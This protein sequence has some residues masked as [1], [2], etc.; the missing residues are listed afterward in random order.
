M[1]LKL[2]LLLLIPLLS[3]TQI[4]I[5]NNQ[6]ICSGDSIQLTANVSGPASGCTGVSDSLVTQVAGG[7][8]SAGTTFNVI[9]T[10]GSPLD[11]TGI[12]QGGTYT[13]TNNP[14]E[15]WM[16]AGDVYANPLPI[17][18]PPYP[19]WVLV[20]SASVNTTGGTSLGYIPI[21]GVTIP[22]GGT[23]SFRVQRLVSGSVSYTNGTGTAG[24][25]TWASDPNIT[26]T[27]GHGGGLT[28][29]FAFSP[30]CFNGAV[31]YGGGASWIDV[32]SGQTIGSGD[33][34]TY[35][36]SQ[37][38]D[39]C[40]ILNCNGI[41]YSDT[42]TINVLNTNI[43]TT[44]FSLC[45]GP[46]ILTAPTGFS[47]YNWSSGSSSS[48]Y[49]VSSPG[50]YYVNCIDPNGVT[51]QSDP[52]SIYPGNIPI[53]LST[54][55][56]VFIC[57]GDTVI[58]NGPPG[59][60]QYSWNTGSTTPFITTTSTGSYNLSVIDGNGCTGTSNTTTISMSPQSIT[61]TTTGYSLCNGSVI[62]DAGSG[63]SSYQWYNNGIMMPNGNSQTFIA[64]TAGNYTVDVTYPTGCTA[65]SIPITIYAATGQ[66]YFFINAIGEDSLCMPNGQV[67]LDAGNYA[68]YNWST[69]ETTQQITVNSL[70][71]Y[72][73]NVVD[74]NGCPG[75]S[76]PPFNV[77]NI[78]NTSPI[79]G[80]ANPTQYQ[81]VTYSV[82]P[83]AGSTYYWD[84]IG[85][86]IQ[87]GAGTNSI[88]VVW[89]T[90][91]IFAFSVVETDINGC[92]GAEISLI[93]NVIF[94]GDEDISI[95]NK[96]LIKITDILGREIQEVKNTVMLY[97]YKD[98]TIEKIII[99]E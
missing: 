32:S 4:N 41:T 33:S 47:N 11:I 49:T 7:N 98:G 22:T 16:Y 91:G 56:S 15:V 42:V 82:I 80:P 60:A 23:Y 68:S 76:N 2:S 44:G 8:G 5:G 26:I 99:N 88:D 79:S 1:K 74:G 50:S 86:T 87:S 78:V 34:L 62:L 20:G 63:F 39:I 14:M 59:F 97:I 29:W 31:H 48:I 46:V 75:A 93:V 53:N 27:E 17:G 21:N 66:F 83:N 24:I 72:Y 51:C 70:G 12:S 10:S 30:R 61:A 13:M 35:T 54:P 77:A 69:G 55:D 6:T 38:T 43:S 19:G 9:N 64:A 18:A 81:T 3:Y 36:P 67:V 40:A 58:I 25:T 45:N 89:N 28:D 90:S 95:D 65:T 52:V 37:T 73:V 92:V 84:I 85:G 96:K 71:S 57:Q 94:S